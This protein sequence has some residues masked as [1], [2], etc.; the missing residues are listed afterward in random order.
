M[1]MRNG[2]FHHAR[3]MMAA[4]AAILA[5]PQFANNTAAR[6]AELSQLGPYVSRG[7]GRAG[8]QASK[9]SVAQDRRAATKRRNQLRNRMAHR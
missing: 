4:I 5:A 7:K 9:R 3:V 8:H 1:G 2:P 6:K